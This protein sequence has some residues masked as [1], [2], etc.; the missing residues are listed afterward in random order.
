MFNFNRSRYTGSQFLSPS[1]E[2]NQTGTI[3]RSLSRPFYYAW[4]FHRSSRKNPASWNEMSAFS[5]LAATHWVCGVENR[6]INVFVQDHFF[7]DWVN[8]NELHNPEPII[9]WFLDRIASSSCYVYWKIPLL[10]INSKW[11]ICLFNFLKQILLYPQLVDLERWEVIQKHSEISS[12]DSIRS[13]HKID[14]KEDQQEPFEDVK[15][16]WIR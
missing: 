2:H 13:P 12:T 10:R 11:L 15:N 1:P 9:D 3:R 6:L 14:N 7:P 4:F 5:S 8:I 16:S